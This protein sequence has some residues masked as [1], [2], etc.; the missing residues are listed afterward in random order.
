MVGDAGL[1]TLG[2]SPVEG[3]FRIRRDISQ[4]QVDEMLV[5]SADA[6]PHLR[7]TRHNDT[8][9]VSASSGSQS[10]G[11]WAAWRQ[12]YGTMVFAAAPE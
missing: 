8:L 4:E 6:F 10:R 9:V 1:P 12:R 3:V 5:A 7:L 2:E 11:E